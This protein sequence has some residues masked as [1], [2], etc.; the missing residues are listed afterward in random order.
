MHIKEYAYKKL[1]IC[2]FR[3]GKNVPIENIDLPPAVRAVFQNS[4][5]LHF[6]YCIILKDSKLCL[7]LDFILHIQCYLKKRITY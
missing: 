5:P 3:Y 4:A 6:L 2:I 1:H 7:N